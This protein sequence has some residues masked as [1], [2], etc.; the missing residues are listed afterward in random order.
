MVG[1]QSGIWARSASF[2]MVACSRFP[3]M[4]PVLPGDF[5][6]LTLDALR[7]HECKGVYQGDWPELGQAIVDA[8]HEQG[9][10]TQE[11]AARLEA[12]WPSGRVYSR[13]SH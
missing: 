11:F 1:L 13:V 2:T 5:R 9:I 3:F 4:F 8:I 7:H 10:S 12:T 6:Q